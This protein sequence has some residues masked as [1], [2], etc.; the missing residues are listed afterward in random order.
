MAGRDGGLVE[1]SQGQLLA[2]QN[3]Q[4][5][6]SQA[7]SAN[8]LSMRAEVMAAVVASQTVGQQ[9]ASVA[10]AAASGETALHIAAATAH[11]EVSD[12]ARDFYGRKIFEPYLRFS[13]PEDEEAYRQ[14]EA[15]WERYIKQQ[16]ALGTPQGELNAA[17]AMIAQMDDAGAH[18]A[19]KAPGFREGR[20]RAAKVRDELAAQLGQPIAQSVVPAKSSASADP[21]DSVPAT[22]PASSDAARVLL[23]AGIVAGDDS[24][25][26]H[27]VAE[28]KARSTV[29]TV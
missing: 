7:G 22:P 10:T 16:Q 5:R 2:L 6:I 17:N 8:L 15:E 25:Q 3:L 1:Q 13:S 14:R 24:N 4:R 20:D 27:G 29:R 18:G 28:A 21:L 12:L 11:R 19:D 26:G 23:A 9:I